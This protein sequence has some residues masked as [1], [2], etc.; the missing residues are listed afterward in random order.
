MG[1]QEFEH[2]AGADEAI[3]A[4]PANTKVLVACSK[5]CW[6]AHDDLYLPVRVGANIPARK[7]P[8]T[9][10]DQAALDAFCHATT[11][12]NTGDN[13][14][15][16]NPHYSELTALYWGWKNV[17]ADYLGL[18]HYRRYFRGS[19][20]NHTLTL[21]DAERLM[22]DSPVVLPTKRHYFT[23]TVGSHYAMTFD[24]AHFDLMTQILEEKE[25]RYAPA[26]GA[27]LRNHEAH[28]LNMFIMRCDILDAYCTWL[29]P[30]L[31]EFDAR[32]DTSAY[33]PFE[34]RATGR[35]AERLL[36]P[37][38]RTNGIPYAECP[39]VTI[40]GA[41]WPQKIAGVAA[42]RL[43]GQKYTHSF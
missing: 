24:A 32:L 8:K 16:C 42:A 31:E 34:A 7:Q 37:W 20:E 14:S 29:F 6:I 22:R 36:D 11:P 12:D 18:C 28:I 19:G 35:V 38:L 10:R 3:Q 2:I 30:L 4:N 27:H 23:E 21:A 33:T 13:A 1:Q 39:T 17:E 41:H 9:A 26:F 43:L 15:D 25:P 40:G 5:P